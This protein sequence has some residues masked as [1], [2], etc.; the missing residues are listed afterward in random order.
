MISC[1]CADLK[2]VHIHCPCNLCSG[3][4]VLL[5]TLNCPMKLLLNSLSTIINLQIVSLRLPYKKYWQVGKFGVLMQ[6]EFWHY[7]NLA[8]CSLQ[9]MKLCSFIIL[10]AFKFG[11]TDPICQIAKSHRQN[12]SIYGMSWSDFRTCYNACTIVRPM[13]CL[14]HQLGRRR[15]GVFSVMKWTTY[16]AWHATSIY[17]YNRNINAHECL[18]YVNISLFGLNKSPKTMC[19]TN[20]KSTV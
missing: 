8:D 6:N 9:H 20:A 1:R 3:R 17:G 10:A 11:V 5:Q 15:C 18:H 12:F 4:A 13:C 14:T 7:F 16:N 19:V 2:P